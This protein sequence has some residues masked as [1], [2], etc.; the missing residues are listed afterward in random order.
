MISRKYKSTFLD[1]DES[2]DDDDD[3]NN[4]KNELI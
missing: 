1:S 2:D 3:N 4:K